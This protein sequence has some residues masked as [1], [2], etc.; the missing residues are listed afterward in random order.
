MVAVLARR[1]RT[2]LKELR[3]TRFPRDI[4]YL[5]IVHESVSPMCPAEVP[6]YYRLHSALAGS[7]YT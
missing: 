4:E 7:W 1:A 5:L 2:T 6:W 3:E